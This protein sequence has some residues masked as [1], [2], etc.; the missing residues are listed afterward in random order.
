M[1]SLN[2]ET[3]AGLFVAAKDVTSILGH[4]AD[5][6]Q[7][8]GRLSTVSVDPQ[9]SL[10]LLNALSRLQNHVQAMKHVT[11]IEAAHVG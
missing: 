7:L 1:H 3:L 8:R 5:R 11:I 2:F 10:E 4:C 6:A 9:E